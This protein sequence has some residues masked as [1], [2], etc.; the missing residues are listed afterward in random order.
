MVALFAA[1]S[2][3]VSSGFRTGESNLSREQA[4]LYATEIIDYAQ[5]MKQTIQT[6]QIN[7]CADTEINFENDI[8][9]IYN[10]PSTPADESCKV[11][12]PN[13]G[14]LRYAPPNENF[15]D[16]SITFE[17]QLYHSEWSFFGIHCVADIGNCS[18]KGHLIMLMGPIKDEIC[19]RI[20]EKIGLDSS[21][22]PM[23]NITIT[24]G[25][26]GS[27]FRGVYY[28]GSSNG[29]VSIDHPIIDGNLTGC[30]QDNI[31]VA[32]GYN[33]FYQVLIAR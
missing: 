25:G 3:V 8:V 21:A 1:L 27:H 13:G 4:D 20:N 5:L 18:T 12:K 11:F 31:G 30:V 6:L 17:S 2:Y 14:A 29:N 24:K 15:I 26:G 19:L 22:I 7:G 32:N 23:D 33:F 28:E 16:S 9:P 10:F